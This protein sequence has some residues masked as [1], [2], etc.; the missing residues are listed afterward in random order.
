MRKL[1]HPAEI[2]NIKAET[3]MKLLSSKKLRREI[4]YYPFAMATGLIMAVA[5]GLTLIFKLIGV[6]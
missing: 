6:M 1:L 3:E 5:T 2:A 4:F